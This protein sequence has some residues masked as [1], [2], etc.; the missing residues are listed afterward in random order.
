MLAYWFTKEKKMKT[1]I[2]KVVSID[3]MGT[4]TLSSL[5]SLQVDCL[6]R[7]SFLSAT[8][9]SFSNIFKIS[10]NFGRNAE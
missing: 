9:L 8:F 3:D 7:V 2:S 6:I 1:K 10:L 5:S 4:D